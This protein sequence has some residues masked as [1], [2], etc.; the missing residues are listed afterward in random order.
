MMK[1]YGYTDNS[2]LLKQLGLSPQ[3][4]KMFLKKLT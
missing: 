3:S 2:D 1:E 4:K